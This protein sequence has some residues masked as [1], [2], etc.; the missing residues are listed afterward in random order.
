MG[1]YID[2]EKKSGGFYFRN[3]YTKR[4]YLGYLAIT[5]IPNFQ[6]DKA[7]KA[8]IEKNKD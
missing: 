5:Y 1:L 2:V 6:F 8:Y 3:G 4:L 7:V